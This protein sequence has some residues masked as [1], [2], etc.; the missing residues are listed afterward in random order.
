MPVLERWTFVRQHENVGKS[1]ILQIIQ[2]LD[3]QEF[4][5]LFGD[6][7]A[8]TQSQILQGYLRTPREV[9]VV[10]TMPGRVS[11]T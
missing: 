6:I 9:E 2:P 8:I 5:A 4:A 11:K 7:I 1:L 10:L 3:R